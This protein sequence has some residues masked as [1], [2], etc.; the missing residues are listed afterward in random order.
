MGVNYA[1]RLR[2]PVLAEEMPRACPS[3]GSLKGS[4]EPHSWL[5]QN[6]PGLPTWDAGK[7]GLLVG[8]C[9]LF[10]FYTDPRWAFSGRG[11]TLI[12]ME[13]WYSEDNS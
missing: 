13:I 6:V 11:L 2:S 12:H 3:H 5:L 8:V 10:L 1:V 9:T 4:G 7:Q